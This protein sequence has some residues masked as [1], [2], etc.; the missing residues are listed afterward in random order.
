VADIIR[1][2]PGAHR[3]DDLLGVDPLEVERGRAEVG[4]A[5]LALDDVERQ[6]SS[7][8]WAWR[9]W[10]GA[11]RRRTPA[12]AASR[13]DSTRTL[14]IAQGRPRVGPS[15]TQNSGPTGKSRR[16]ASQG[17]SC[18][19]PQ[20]SSGADLTAATALAVAHEQR[21]APGV[22][23]AFAE[24]Q[25]LRDTQAA[26]KEHDD[27]TRAAGSRGGRRWPRA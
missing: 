9:S 7:S 11:K 18:S 6:A 3:G 1:C 24:R 14:A 26:A 22:E 20:A 25:R 12:W 21:A 27:L 4:V 23:V 17:E 15:T 8:A 16:A 10:C 13:R 19:Q 2:A 5:E